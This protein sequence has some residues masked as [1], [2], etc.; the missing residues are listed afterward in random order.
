[1]TDFL[2]FNLGAPFLG[3]VGEVVGKKMHG[4]LLSHLEIMF[5]H[6]KFARFVW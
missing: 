5:L 1:M 2:F 4:F 6:V 3:G